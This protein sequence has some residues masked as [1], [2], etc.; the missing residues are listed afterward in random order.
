[1]RVADGAAD[2]VR[3]GVGV[4]CEWNSAAWPQCGQVTLA[5]RY[6][7]CWAPGAVRWP[8]RRSWCREAADR[9][10]VVAEDVGIVRGGEVGSEF[11]D[12][13]V[14]GLTDSSDEVIDLSLL[15]GR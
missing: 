15:L 13:G 12:L 9:E 1:M 6:P 2:Q 3:W 8:W 7:W 11:A 14:D 4:R 5:P 10:F